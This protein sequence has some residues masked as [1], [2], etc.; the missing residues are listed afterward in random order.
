MNT[1]TIAIEDLCIGMYV[2][3]LDIAWLKTPF[4]VHRLEIKTQ[5]QINAIRDSGA[6]FVTIDVSR[7]RNLAPTPAPPRV[8]STAAPPESTAYAAELGIAKKVRAATLKTLQRTLDIVQNKEQIAVGELHPLVDKTVASLLRN[9]SAMLT[10]VSQRPQGNFLLNHCCN[11]LTLALLLGQ[12]LG[13]SPTELS[14]LGIAAL[15]MDIGWIHLPSD[16]FAL[17]HAYTEA[18]YDLV[19]QH[20]D[21][22]VNILEQSGAELEVID[23]VAN[24]H[25][26]CNGEGYPAGISGDFVPFGSQI[27]SVVDHFDSLVNG[28]YDSPSIIPATALRTLYGCARS[29][30][31]AP[32]IVQA[33]ISV[34]GIYPI[35]SAVL[36]NTG[37]R[38]VVTR[39]NW[40]APLLPR[41]RVMYNRA[42]QALTQPFELDL[43]SP[44]ARQEGRTIRSVIDPALKAE[45][46]RG[47]LKRP[48]A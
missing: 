27:L 24:H 34:L 48:V 10:L 40:K 41:V 12:R 2:T 9:S 13:L 33:L 20:L 29:G 30:G 26:R 31:H 3:G 18:E 15:T 25:E 43:A 11:S 17:G 5:E 8:E 4:L 32:A 7:S 21:Y 36:L 1:K 14:H 28:Y 22:S 44:F 46:P 42:H 19:R 45:D 38:A 6:Q 23:L 39:V 37:E 47:I 16:W 35:G